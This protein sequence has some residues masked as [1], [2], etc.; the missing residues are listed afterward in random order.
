MYV[1]KHFEGN[2]NP[3][4]PK[5]SKVFNKVT[6]GPND[7]KRL[8]MSQANSRVV[9][10]LMESLASQFGLGFLNNLV[11]IQEFKSMV[12]KSILLHRNV[13]TL[14]NV[15]LQDWGYFSNKN[16]NAFNFPE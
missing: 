10:A 9:F 3:A 4:I 6:E 5:G 2:I 14:Q 16:K 8:E 15:V 13:V 11:P 1:L 7:D 12:F